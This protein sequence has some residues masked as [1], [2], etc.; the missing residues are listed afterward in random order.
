[1]VKEPTPSSNRAPGG[2]EPLHSE[3]RCDEGMREIITL[4]LTEIPD[5]IHVLHA[6][7]DQG[8][9]VAFGRLVHQIQGAGG[10]YGYPLVT[11]ASMQLSR[12]IE[13]SGDAWPDACDTH[14]QCLVNVLW[15]AHAGL[16][17]LQE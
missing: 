3:Y 2:I 8:N 10:G 14:L 11:Q 5:R 9:R 4:F 6:L 15:R 12:C 16:S 17:D 7:R 1:M 13:M